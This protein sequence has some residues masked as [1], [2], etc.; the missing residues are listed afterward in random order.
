MNTANILKDMLRENTGVA[1]CDSGGEPKYDANGNYIGSSYGYGRNYEINRHVDFE[2][3]S[4][5]TLSF[6][7][8]NIEFTHNIYHWLKERCEYS[9]ELNKLFEEFSGENENK[10]WLELMEGFPEYLGTLTDDEG[11]PLYGE[12]GGIYGEGKPF[13]VN[14]YNGES[15]LSQVIQFVY[16]SDKDNEF[17]ALQ[18]H[19][20]ADVR[21]GYTSPKIFSVG[22][23]GEL[24]ILD[25][26][27]GEIFC[28][29]ENRH[30]DAEAIKAKQESQLSLE[31]IVPSE[32]DFEERHYWGTDDGY[33]WYRDFTCGAGYKQLETY[34]VRDLEEEDHWE[35]GVLCIR[36]GVGY[37][38]ICGARLAG[39]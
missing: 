5:V 37:C 6:S 15:L 19:G 27:K 26:A 36:D 23:L 39:R 13:C 14:T 2:K 34:E 10:G 12:F 35:P 38:P 1:L 8:G 17:I 29:G 24:D 31:G 33:H 20:G 3:I 25:C 11:N 18:I 32:I 28:T 21:G 7:N 9:E 16:F 30:P 4:P 22:N